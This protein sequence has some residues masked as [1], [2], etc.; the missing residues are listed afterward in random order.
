MQEFALT[1]VV[2]EKMEA[3]AKA[4]EKIQWETVDQEKKNLKAMV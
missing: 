3:V 4:R 2:T 1:T